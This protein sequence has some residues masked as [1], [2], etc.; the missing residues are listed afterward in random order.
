MTKRDSKTKRK[1]PAKRYLDCVAMKR[2]IQAKIYHEIKDMTREQELAYWRK[3][4]ER[5][6]W[7]D[8]WREIHERS[9]AAKAQRETRNRRRK[10]G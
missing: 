3:G 10:S 2:R 4:A 7:G 6:P 5:G 9:A 8:W 1:K